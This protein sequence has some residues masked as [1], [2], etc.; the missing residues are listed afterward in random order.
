MYSTKSAEQRSSHLHSGGRLKLKSAEISGVKCVLKT[1][2]ARSGS[3]DRQFQS[4]ATKNSS[5]INKTYSNTDVA[6]KVKE[7]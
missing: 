7:C 2:N 1:N 4:T 5:L 3:L 6:H